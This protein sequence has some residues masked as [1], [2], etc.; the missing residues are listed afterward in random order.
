MKISN[1]GFWI[2]DATTQHKHDPKLADALAKLFRNS[3]VYDLG[4]G[5]G[6]YVKHFNSKNNIVAFGI[7][8]NPLTDMYDHCMTG[9]LTKPINMQKRN[10]VLSLEVGEHI[11]KEL[12]QNY[13]DNLK[14][15]NRE[16][17]VLSWAIPG[18]GGDGHVNELPNEDV[19]AMFP[20]YTYDV[21]ASLYLRSKSTLWWF[22]NTIMVFRKNQD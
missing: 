2:G 6:K 12:T 5:E 14:N 19:I 13:I 17:I 9:D 20:E 8:G 15:L 11:P 3:T 21:E 22:K 10:W 18:Q 7:D 4:C 1:T 16:G